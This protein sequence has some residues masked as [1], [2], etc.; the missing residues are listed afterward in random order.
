MKT[1]LLSVCYVKLVRCPFSEVRKK[2]L[3]GILAACM[4]FVHEGRLWQKL[5]PA[6]KVKRLINA[7]LLFQGALFITS[8]FVRG[9]CSG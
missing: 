7:L 1:L 9:L 6:A 4:W 5:S 8:S 3:M 2:V